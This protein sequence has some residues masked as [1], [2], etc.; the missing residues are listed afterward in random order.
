MEH[1]LLDQKRNPRKRSP[2]QAPAN[3]G[4]CKIG[5]G[6]QHRVE[7]RIY[8][9]DG[10]EGS[11]HEFLGR[12]LLA[13]HEFGEPESIARRVICQRDHVRYLLL[14]TAALTQ[15]GTRAKLSLKAAVRHPQC[16]TSVS[17]LSPARREIRHCGRSCGTQVTTGPMATRLQKF[18]F[19]RAPRR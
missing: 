15:I 10:R 13:S 2:W 8:L 16:G 6:L 12:D 3:L 17:W 1:Q 18:Q 5:K 7:P 19:N 9:F 4:T 14:S 11:L